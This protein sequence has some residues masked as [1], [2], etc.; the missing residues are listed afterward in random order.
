MT[1]FKAAAAGCAFLSL[2]LAFAAPALAQGAAPGVARPVVTGPYTCTVGEHEGI[3][4]ADAHTTADLFCSELL[5]R[6]GAPGEYEVRFGKLG[7]R[8]LFSVRERTSGEER[9]VLL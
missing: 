4:D 6:R 5:S 9:R 7:S 3:A 1:I 8:L 2:S